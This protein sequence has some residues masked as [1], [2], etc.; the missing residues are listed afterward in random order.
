MYCVWI[1]TV[2]HQQLFE[3]PPQ[4]IHPKIPVWIV[5]KTSHHS[6]LVTR[7]L[8]TVPIYYKIRVNVCGDEIFCSANQNRS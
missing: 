3:S 4:K 1:F 5:S 2:E 7:I 8:V 6:T